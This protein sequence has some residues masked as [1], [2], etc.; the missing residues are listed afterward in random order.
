MALLEELLSF[1]KHLI[2]DLI[3]F[4]L[5]II[6]L[7]LSLAFNALFMKISLDESRKGMFLLSV[8][9]WIFII[10]QYLT[11]FIN[12]IKI[13]EKLSK[14]KFYNQTRLMNFIFITVMFFLSLFAGEYIY[15][16]SLYILMTTIMFS[17]IIKK[18]DN[19]LLTQSFLVILIFLTKNIG[20]FSIAEIKYHL[21]NWIL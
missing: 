19:Y 4:I 13:K 15:Q 2:K 8:F 12:Q 17:L 7:F 6:L 3:P 16:T 10:I 5:N 18:L 21:F 1:S 14:S 9:Q 11:I 20:V